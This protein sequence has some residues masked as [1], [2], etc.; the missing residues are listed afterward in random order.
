MTVPEHQ[1]NVAWH[2]RV[3]LFP[4]F[5]RLHPGIQRHLVA[6]LQRRL[7]HRPRA[8]VACTEFLV[9]YAVFD[10]QQP[11]AA[12]DARS[13]LQRIRSW[14]LCVRSKPRAVLG[15]KELPV[16]CEPLH[17]IA[18]GRRAGRFDVEHDRTRLVDNLTARLPQAQAVVCVF[19]VRRSEPVIEP[20]GG[21]KCQ[22]PGQQERARPEVNRP[23]EHVGRVER[24]VTA[25]VP[26]TR[27][28]L[29]D[30]GAGLLQAAVH[31]NELPNHSANRL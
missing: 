22:A 23:S 27:A 15:G 11:A 3:R 8:W 7:D 24:I 25:S 30:D 19:V 5:G 13:R 2:V 26:L 6:K 9:W 29:P 10:K 28:I 12:R 17:D 4:P 31:V 14:R 18:R 16:P 1:L 20:T 21:Q